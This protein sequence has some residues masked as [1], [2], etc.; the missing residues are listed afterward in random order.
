VPDTVWLTVPMA[1]VLSGTFIV[2]AVTGAANDEPFANAVTDV[3]IDA[4]C[5]ELE[6]DVCTTIGEPARPRLAVPVD[7][8]LW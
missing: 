7:G 3:P 5:I 4:I 8:Y 2:L 6:H 1:L